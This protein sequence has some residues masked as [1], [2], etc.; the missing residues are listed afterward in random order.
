MTDSSKH[1]S[2]TLACAFAPQFISVGFSSSIAWDVPPFVTDVMGAARNLGFDGT[3]GLP[4]GSVQLGAMGFVAVTYGMLTVQER[5]EDHLFM[6]DEGPWANIWLVFDVFTSAVATVLFMP[7]RP[8]PCVV[9]VC[10][11]NASHAN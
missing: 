11:E 1:V 6:Q 9:L 10:R 4:P 5:V 3:V 2:L 7:V 8:V